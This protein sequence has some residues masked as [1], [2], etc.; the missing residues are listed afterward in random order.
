VPSMTIGPVTAQGVGAQGQPVPGLTPKILEAAF[1]LPAGGES[2]IQ[3]VGN[4][5]YF[6]VRVERVIPKSM[7]PLAEVK[8]QLTRVWMMREMVKRMQAKADTFVARL[9]KGETLEAVAT[10]A[11]TQVARVAGLDRQNAE[12]SQALSRD[13]LVK[14]FGAK[15]GEVFVAEDPRFG[16]VVAK[17]EAVRAPSGPNLARLTEEGRPQMTMGVFREIGE[18]ARR[19][20]RQEIKV[21]IYPD[22][23]RLALGLEP[24]KE[25]SK[26]GAAG[27]AEKSK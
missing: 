22:K 20:A 27:K 13:A 17:L 8:P 23:A 15:P 11:G 4:G 25:D 18:T 3:E 26:A 14:A 1:A 16:L 19:A 2:D 24:L 21:K 12:Q 10:S 5:E 9:N 6:A 7:P